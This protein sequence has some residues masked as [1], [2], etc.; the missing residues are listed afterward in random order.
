MK[1][2]IIVLILLST[3][4]FS[5]GKSYL[6]SFAIK[7]F[8][9]SSYSDIKVK[10]LK[11]IKKYPGCDIAR[12]RVRGDR[13]KLAAVCNVKRKAALRKFYSELVRKIKYTVTKGKLITKRL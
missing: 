10:V 13:S 1:K 4:A 5:Y 9:I 2:S 6:Q 11:L 8:E 12:N 7:G 3:F